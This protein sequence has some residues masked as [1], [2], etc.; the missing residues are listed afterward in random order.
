LSGGGP[1]GPAN[2]RCAGSG[3]YVLFHDGA[4]AGSEG[5]VVE[6]TIDGGVTWTPVLVAPMLQGE[7]P[8]FSQLPGIDA[9]TGPFQVLD[10][11]TAFFFGTCPAC[12]RGTT[13]LTRTAGEGG[14]SFTRL[15]VVA[16]PL[17]AGWFAD[18]AHG[19]V[20]AGPV[21]GPHHV[22]RTTDGG[23]TWRR[24]FPH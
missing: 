18:S 1:I 10:P 11:F 9:D 20:V 12:D 23:E 3:A 19:W 2:V 7:D 8:S 24:V 17:A 5:Y 4:A 16:Q 15:A 14:G 21:G 6:R 22:Y 13:S